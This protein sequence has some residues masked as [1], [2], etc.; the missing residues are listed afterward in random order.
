M[1]IAARILAYDDTNRTS[2][3]C[4]MI[5]QDP[6]SR[7]LVPRALGVG[8]MCIPDHPIPRA[9]A[10]GGIWSNGSR[11]RRPW[12]IELPSSLP[13]V[14]IGAS[15]GGIEAFRPVLRKNAAR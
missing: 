15:A 3:C 4:L 12:I 7:C 10:S 6:R 8:K 1:P 5:E 13:I 14:G 2:E 11:R 9:I